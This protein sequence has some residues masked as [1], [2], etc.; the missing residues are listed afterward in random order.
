MSARKTRGKKAVPEETRLSMSA[1]NY[2]LSIFRLQE[3]QPRLTLTQLA[4]HLR[5]LPVAEGLGTSLP[6][7]S[8]MIRRMNR[9]GLVES[10]QTRGVVLTNDG[11]RSAESIVRRHR[12]AERMVVDLLG[13]ELA[14]AHVEAHRLEHAISPELEE[15]IVAKLGNPK[16]CPFGHPVPGSGY[17]SPQ[18]ALSI[19]QAA[20]GME[21]VVDRIPEDDQALLEY[22]V[23]NRL[24]P[25]EVVSI[26][27][28]A[29]S[30]G[31]ITLECRGAQMPFSYE[32]ASR[33]WARPRTAADAREDGPR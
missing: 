17:I 10:D 19:D 13:V 3:Q 27:E 11:R 30:R 32:V 6:S 14:R 1:E 26:R 29:T 7:V 33:I 23:A 31:V 8:A 16:T 25:G 24:I 12:L 9:E 15:D 5:T 22:M 18:D 4:E 2:L 21:L 20:P 28:M